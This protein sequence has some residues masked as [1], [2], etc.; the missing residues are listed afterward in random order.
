MLEWI[1]SH[2]LIFVFVFPNCLVNI[3]KSRI[4]GLC[5]RLGQA[6]VPRPGVEPG[7]AS[8]ETPSPT[9]WTAWEFQEQTAF[10]LMRPTFI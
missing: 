3:L 4:H 9:H 5:P 10:D 7:P 8:S 2:I 6:L 1:F